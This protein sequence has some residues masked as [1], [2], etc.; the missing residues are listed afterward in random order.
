MKRK[1]QHGLVRANILGI[2]DG[3]GAVWVGFRPVPF[4]NPFQKN[5]LTSHPACFNGYPFNPTRRVPT[6]PDSDIKKKK[7]SY[8]L[9]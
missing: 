3:N 5:H 6:Q 8:C 1:R 9:F 4:K 2:R 7:K